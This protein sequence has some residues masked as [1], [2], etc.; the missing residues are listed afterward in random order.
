MSLR[1]RKVAKKREDILRSASRVIANKGYKNATMEDIA[2]ELLM[3]KGALYYYYKNKEEILYSCHEVILSVAIKNMETI[4]SEETSSLEKMK[5]AI[6]MHLDIVIREKEVFSLIVKPE[7]VFSESN[8]KELI[9]RRD[10]YTAMFDKIMD[11]GVRR[12]EFTI[13]NK[14][15]L[16]MIILGA[17]NWVQIWYSPEGEFSKK[18]IEEIYA[19]HLL[20]LLV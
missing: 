2:A 6:K 3:T 9:E 8:I 11:E 18:E 17:I 5:K 20:K 1:E 12:K 16:R 13:L 4:Y 14:K 10:N 7:K 15:M 19:E